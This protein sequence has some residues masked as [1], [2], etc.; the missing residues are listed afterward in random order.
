M[1][2][3]HRHPA[4]DQLPSHHRVVH[5][6]LLTNPGQGLPGCVQSLRFV[7]LL[8]A[9]PLV[10]HRHTSLTEDLQHA[11]LAETERLHQCCR[12]LAGL[13][14]SDNLPDSLLSQPL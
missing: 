1:R 14:S 10:P 9:Q 12:G 8:S 2:I 7:D 13:V 3:S 5:V 11:A 4:S 6:K